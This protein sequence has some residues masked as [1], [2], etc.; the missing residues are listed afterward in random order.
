MSRLAVRG[1]SASVFRSYAWLNTAAP[2]P[3]RKTPTR[4]ITQP[5]FSGPSAS[6][7][8][9]NVVNTRLAI[10]ITLSSEKTFFMLLAIRPT[11]LS[12]FT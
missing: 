2:A 8:P 6:T 4:V 3:N 1:I 11:G 12:V 10:T 7:Y 9:V 5:A